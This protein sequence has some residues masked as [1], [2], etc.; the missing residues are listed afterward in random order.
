ME[1]IILAAGRGQRMEGLAKPFYKPLLEINGMPLVAYAV[2][3]ASAAGAELVTVVASSANYEDIKDAVSSYS[4]WARLLV[5]EDPSGPGHAT[6]I[7]LLEA[8]YE[9]TMLLMS[10][11]VMNQH[12]V[13]DMAIHSRIN[14]TDAVGTRTVTM[15]QASRFTRIR[16]KKNKESKYTFVEGTP[17]ETDDQWPDGSGVKVWCGPLIFNSGVA[18]KV[19]Q[20]AWI[21]RDSNSS[22]MKIGPYLNDILQKETKLFDVSAFD[23]GIPSAY[24]EHKNGM[25]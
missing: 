4:R 17:V 12:E 23:V 15:D 24:A 14:K 3:Y 16:K 20:N 25:K 1:A 21:R 19:F 13:V 5:Q 2:E 11:N 9:Q 8:E 22:E 10:D 7:A 6:M 18:L